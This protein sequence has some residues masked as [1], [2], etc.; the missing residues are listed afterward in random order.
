MEDTT[1]K[2]I[3][4]PFITLDGFIEGSQGELDWATGGGEFDCKSFYSIGG[5]LI[6]KWGKT[7]NRMQGRFCALP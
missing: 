7:S 2:V 1:R 4:S 6:I 5:I 3:A